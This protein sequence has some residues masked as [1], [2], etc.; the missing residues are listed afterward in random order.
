MYFLPH[1]VSYLAILYPTK[2]VCGTFRYLRLLAFTTLSVLLQQPCLKAQLFS[3]SHEAL[4]NLHVL[5]CTIQRV[6]KVRESW[7]TAGLIRHLSSACS[8]CFW[9]LL[10]LEI[11]AF[12]IWNISISSKWLPF[13]SLRT[14]LICSLSKETCAQLF[15]N[16]ENR[17]F[18]ES[19]E[20]YFHIKTS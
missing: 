7:F 9:E 19:E 16:P 3:S 20:E 14:T 18:P 8:E 12:K 5:K 10:P 13:K 11:N 15:Q 17:S 1:A 6:W 4:H 2:T